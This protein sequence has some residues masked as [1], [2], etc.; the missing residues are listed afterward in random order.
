MKTGLIMEGGAMRGM[1]TAGV[2]DVLMEEM[3]IRDS[4][5]T[6]LFFFGP[7]R[8]FWKTGGLTSDCDRTGRDQDHVF[9]LIPKI[10]DL[11]DQNLHFCQIQCPRFR[12]GQ[13]CLL[14]TSSPST[15]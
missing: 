5:C 7:F 6:G 12:M 9:S 3:C 15:S 10:C 8:S 13:S 1:F 14:Y 11:T 2:I 4:R